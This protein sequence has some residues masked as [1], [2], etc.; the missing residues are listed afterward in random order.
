MQRIE[1][2]LPN[3][4]GIV[5]VSLDEYFEDGG[6][7]K[8]DLPDEGGRQDK[9]GYDIQYQILAQEHGNW[10]PKSPYDGS[11]VVLKVVPIIDNS[12]KNNFKHLKITLFVEKEFNSDTNDMEPL[13]VSYEPAQEG[14][15]AV[16]HAS[17][18]IEKT[19]TNEMS[20]EGK[21]LGDVGS[22]GG[23]ITN[24]TKTAHEVLKLHSI[25]SHTERKSARNKLDRA[26]VWEIT[27]V[28]PARGVGD[29]ITIAM[30]IRRTRGSE[31]SIIADTVG[32][33]GRFNN[34]L[35][36]CD[37]RNKVVRIP[38]FGKK[39]KRLE[40][41]NVDVD[42]TD[43]HALSQGTPT[44]L[45]DI[46]KKSGVH[47]TETVS[48]VTCYSEITST[49]EPT[50]PAASPT[51]QPSTIAMVN[52]DLTKT[53]R[54]IPQE[55][56]PVPMKSLPRTIEPE[57]LST[58]I[59]SRIA[60]AVGDSPG[61]RVGSSAPVGRDDNDIT[62]IPVSLSA[63]QLRARATRHQKIAGLY[64]ILAKLHMEEAEDSLAQAHAAYKREIEKSL[65]Q[66]SDMARQRP[67]Q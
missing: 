50:D 29:S 16:D 17:Y 27:A 62:S 15:I 1:T 35:N 48:P 63:T 46:V 22:G 20:L 18:S 45:S 39:S 49:S 33:L 67:G 6:Q 51:L 57:P 60:A 44:A 30:L 28:D 59:P 55:L 65:E 2:V 52:S 58:Q 7:V 43:L 25:K 38:S 37:K 40:G 5:T 9:H 66:T 64:E 61:V 32:T 8:S 41:M 10:E 47:L 12:L 11:L 13:I 14:A 19:H 34:L 36:K 24:S 21:F 53:P 31:F 54:S 3:D 4:E 26:V 23:K 42:E 56:P